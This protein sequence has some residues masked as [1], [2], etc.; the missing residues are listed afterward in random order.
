M[1]PRSPRRL[2]S[3]VACAAAL[4]LAG[5]T[6]AAP[7]PAA[8]GAVE[9]REYR[10]TISATD[11]TDFTV[12]EGKIGD[13][14]ASWTKVD[15][16]V[17][18]SIRTARQGILTVFDPPGPV[19]LILSHSFLQAKVSTRLRTSGT[20]HRGYPCGCGP[21]SEYGPCP[22]VPADERLNGN[23]A[24]SSAKGGSLGLVLRKRTLY[25]LAGGPVESLLDDCPLATSDM[26]PD[27]IG[28]PGEIPLDATALGEIGR[29]KPG[30]RTQIREVVRHAGRDRGCPRGA[31]RT[32]SVCG[33]FV[34]TLDVRRV[35]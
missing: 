34:Y 9:P 10:T 29:L 6:G 27:E 22:D 30:Q 28:L 4:A 1:S 12:R 33:V 16:L 17:T 20:Q 31:G 11:S 3:N 8:A 14:C 2:P 7:A 19:G 5:L 18:T 32:V 23:C 25:G 15:G 21:T 13:R 24:R 35:E 26:L